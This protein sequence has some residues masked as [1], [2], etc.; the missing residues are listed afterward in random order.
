MT[1]E[2]LRKRAT[3]SE[4]T[5]Q[6]LNRPHYFKKIKDDVERHELRAKNTHFRR[7]LLKDRKKEHYRNDYERMRGIIAFSILPQGTRENIEKRMKE[8]EKFQL[9]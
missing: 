2:K 4:I 9:T 5:Q 3:H 8:I 1:N 7:K 6:M